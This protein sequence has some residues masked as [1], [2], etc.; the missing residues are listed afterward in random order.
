MFIQMILYSVGV[1]YLTRLYM[2]LG[3]AN[4]MQVYGEKLDRASNGSSFEKLFTEQDQFI[5]NDPYIAIILK[6][7]FTVYR[8]SCC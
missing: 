4:E 7:Q 1:Y 5:G 2:Q 6:S 3:E 8:S